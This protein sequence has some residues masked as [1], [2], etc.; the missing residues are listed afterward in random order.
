MKVRTD[1][2]RW[3]TGFVIGANGEF[4]FGLERAP[5]AELKVMTDEGI[6]HAARLLG[7]DRALGL[8][9]GIVEGLDRVPLVAARR[10]PLLEETWVVILGHDARGRPEPH[11]GVVSK[12]PHRE[13]SGRRIAWVDVPGAPGHPVLTADG[14]LVA[15]AIRRGK[16]R[17]HVV[18]LED[19]TPFLERVV[20]GGR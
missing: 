14:S 10:D 19:V 9:V 1:S 3:V 16:R 2:P 4:V 6:E 20:L 11:A 5:T 13:K 7:F 17:T 15:I 18:P 8:G 12:P